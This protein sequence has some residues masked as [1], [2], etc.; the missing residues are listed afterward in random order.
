VIF[1]IYSSLSIA[2][3][4]DSDSNSEPDLFVKIIHSKKK[5]DSPYYSTEI[6]PQLDLG[7][8]WPTK[9]ARGFQKASF[10]NRNERLKTIERLENQKRKKE[11]I[12]D[13]ASKKKN[14]I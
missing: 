13:P 9:R 11:V 12:K 3:Y 6:G 2:I 14:L 1:T 5:M 7:Y 10:Y 8:Q 4:D